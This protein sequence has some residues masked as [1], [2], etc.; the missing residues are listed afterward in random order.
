MRRISLSVTT[1]ASGDAD[2]RTSVAVGLLHA[3]HLSVGTLDDSTTTDITI[4]DAATGHTLLAVSNVTADAMYMP[5][6][7]THNAADGSASLY[8]AAGEAVLDRLP[9][10][11]EIRVVV[12]Q[13]GNAKTGT[14]TFYVAESA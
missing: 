12:A 9:V 3:V 14:L 5:R 11:G 8:A 1:D 7:A 6:A 4:T 13:G 2:E 10:S